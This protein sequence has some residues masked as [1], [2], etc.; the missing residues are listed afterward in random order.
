MVQNKIGGLIMGFILLFLG[1][2]VLA[3]LYRVFSTKIFSNMGHH[4]ANKH[5]KDE[6]GIDEDENKYR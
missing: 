6:F 5:L 3:L 1:V 4:I 2:L